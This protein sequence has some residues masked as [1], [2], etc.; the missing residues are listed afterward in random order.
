MQNLS[1]QQERLLNY[2]TKGLNFYDYIYG[3][4]SKGG[5]PPSTR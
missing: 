2:L 1:K 4:Y 3:C 5:R